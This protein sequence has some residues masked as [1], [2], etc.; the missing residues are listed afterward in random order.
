MKKILITGSN[1]YIGNS[2]KGFLK[3]YFEE[4]I[5]NS[6]S[7]KNDS[8][9]K[10]N[11][12]E[13]DVV[14][15]LAAIVHKKEKPLMKEIYFDVNRNLAIEVGIRAK[16]AGVKQF[17]F[18]STMAVYGEE[19]KI[20]EEIVI[21]NRTEPKPKTYYGISKLEAE[22]AL[23]QLMDTHFK[24]VVIRPPMIY[25][26][27]CPGNYAKLEKLAVKASVFPMIENKR[28]VLH[29]DKLC[30]YV[31]KYID[32]EATGLYLPQ[33][34]EYAVTSMLVKELA[35]KNGKKIILSNSMGWFI[36]LIAKKNNLISKIFGN[37][38]YEK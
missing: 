7:L 5:I 14:F 28:S 6:I 18:M 8:W 33:D 25:G 29:I 31:K 10:L 26:P 3:D 12:S 1:S 36:K 27:N 30:Q 17:I 23:N 16:E 11:F 19:G 4:Y 37:L 32:D 21:S 13:Y 34:D 24:V 38:V 9:K 2:F 15:H 20:D 35:E 22:N